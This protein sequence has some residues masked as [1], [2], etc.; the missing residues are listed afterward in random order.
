VIKKKNID[1]RYENRKNAVLS[2][3]PLPSTVDNCSARRPTGKTSV[4]IRNAVRLSV[5]PLY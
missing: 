3:S 4:V 2:L 5:T 1:R